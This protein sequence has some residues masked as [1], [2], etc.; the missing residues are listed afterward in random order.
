MGCNWYK[1]FGPLFIL[2]FLS[3]TSCH[4]QQSTPVDS[5]YFAD[6]LGLGMRITLKPIQWWQ[7]ISYRLPALN[8]Q[9]ETSCSNFMVEAI[10]TK[11][12][13]PGLVIGTDRIVRCNPAAHHYHL[14]L[15]HAKFHHDGRL[16]DP[17]DW[18]APPGNGKSPSLAVALSLVPGLGRVYAGHP[19]DGVF[20]FIMVAGFAYNTYL[21]NQAGNQFMVG[22]NSGLLTLFWLAD[23]Y[24]AYRTA[25]LSP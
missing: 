9:F 8:C 15:P 2:L 12:V 16:I 17:L 11:G 24:G 10:L 5:L 3:S 23:F 13:L 20:S 25:K 22:L 21:H 6:S 19:V 1:I 4:G 7:R 14:Q 18:S